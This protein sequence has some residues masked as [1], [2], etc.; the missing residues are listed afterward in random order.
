MK[1]FTKKEIGLWLGSIILIVGSFFIFDRENYMTL[2]ASLIGVTS[3]ILNAKG[4]P[5]GQC[6]MEDSRYVS[7]VVC[8]VAFWVNDLYGFYSWKRME[9]RQSM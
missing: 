5:F 3:I 4:N 6:L 9:K 2:A 8:F 7:V 1:Y